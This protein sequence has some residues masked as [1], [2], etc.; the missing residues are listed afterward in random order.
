MVFLQNV[1]PCL[2][3]IFHSYFVQFYALTLFC[4]FCIRL[5]ALLSPNFMSIL[6][7][8]LPLILNLRPSIL[9]ML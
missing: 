9:K 2:Q 5:F 8:F 6:V 7:A 1:N 3:Q 4:N